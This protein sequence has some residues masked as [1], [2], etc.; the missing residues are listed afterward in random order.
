MWALYWAHNQFKTSLIIVYQP[1]AYWVMG[2]GLICAPTTFQRGMMKI[3]IDY[4]NK[5]MK[6]FLDDFIV[7]GT[8]D[9]HIEHL[10]KCLIK[11]RENGVSLNPEKCYFC[12]NSGRLL[13][14]VVCTERL[15]VNLKKVEVIKILPPPTSIRGIRSFFGQTSHSNHEKYCM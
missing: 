7:Y 5:F 4:L 8:K 6:V 11:C 13:W 15:L 1:F 12:I 14:H 3:F 2:F 9:D 10:E